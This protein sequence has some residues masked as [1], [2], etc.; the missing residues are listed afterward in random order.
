MLDSDNMKGR[1]YYLDNSLVDF[2]WI[3]YRTSEASIKREREREG[4]RE[5]RE[6]GSNFNDENRFIRFH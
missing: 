6:R 1:K 3:F 5:G 4:G 2:T